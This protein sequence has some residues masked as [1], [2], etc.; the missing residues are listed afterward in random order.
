MYCKNKK[1]DKRIYFCDT[2]IKITITHI[3][4]TIN[5]KHT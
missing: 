4:D 2:Q 3:I 5:Y 1:T